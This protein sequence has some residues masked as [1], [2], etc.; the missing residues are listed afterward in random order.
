MFVCV[1]LLLLLL[2][3]LLVVPSCGAD[4]LQCHH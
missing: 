2:L 3:L 1:L 4:A